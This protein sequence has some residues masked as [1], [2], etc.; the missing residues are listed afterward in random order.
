MNK[1]ASAGL[2]LGLFASAELEDGRT[3]RTLSNLPD[4][5]IYFSQHLSSSVAGDVLRWLD[6]LPS[7]EWR[8]DLSR[9][10]VHYG[11]RY[12]Y[13]SKSITPDM[14]IGPLPTEVKNLATALRDDGH[15][16]RVP[17]QVIV[18]EY[19]PGQGIAM[20]TDH[21]GF[22]PT[23][24]T[25]S[26]GDAWTMDFRDPRTKQRCAHLL[27]IGSILILSGEARHHWQHGIAK[28]K[29][30]P[31]GRKRLRRVSLTFRTVDGI[32]RQDSAGAVESEGTGLRG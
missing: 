14:E 3:D 26:L 16:E 21:P 22:G 8:T 7:S 28:R 18:N 9:R 17:D 32:N 24:A 2:D 13:R 10:V 31:N 23:I 19:L 1:D 30:E 15:F 20:H 5:C 27:E 11:W 6:E 12:D 29:T 25:V 4:G